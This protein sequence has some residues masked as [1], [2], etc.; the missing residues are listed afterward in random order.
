MI[1]LPLNVIFLLNSEYLLMN[2]VTDRTISASSNQ[3]DGGSG[4]GNWLMSE[5][6]WRDFFR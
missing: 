5:L 6:L 3:N 1:Y 2:Y 4:T